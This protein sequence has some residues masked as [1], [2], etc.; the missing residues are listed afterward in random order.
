MLFLIPYISYTAFKVSSSVWAGESLVATSQLKLYV[1]SPCRHLI[2]MFFAQLGFKRRFEL[3]VSG[4]ERSLPCF[5]ARVSPTWPWL[6]DSAFTG[7]NIQ[8]WWEAVVS[9]VFTRSAALP[10]CSFFGEAGNSE[11]TSTG[12]SLQQLNLSP[13]IRW[14]LPFM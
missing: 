8:V 5:G 2:S 3:C 12:K 13:F 4:G 7:K 1:S 11:A 6:Q 9:S 14:F 10:I